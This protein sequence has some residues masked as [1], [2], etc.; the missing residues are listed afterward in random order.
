[1]DIRFQLKIDVFGFI[2]I[3]RKYLLSSMSHFTESVCYILLLLLG[4]MTA[5]TVP[6]LTLYFMTYFPSI[7]PTIGSYLTAIS[8]FN[9]HVT[10]LLFSTVCILNFFAKSDDM[11][12][13]NNF[14]FFAIVFSTFL[15]YFSTYTLM[16]LGL[17]FKSSI[18]IVLPWLTIISLGLYV[19][20]KELLYVFLAAMIP[21]AISSLF[22][23]IANQ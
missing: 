1:M 4:V 3:R 8:G 23:V 2:T 21:Y 7:F 22:A 11:C 12:G 14:L 6:A 13:L 9:F 5:A 16:L 15:P 20:S 18:L 19:K 10:I 17:T